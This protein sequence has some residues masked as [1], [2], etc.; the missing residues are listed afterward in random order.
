MT[1]T[2]SL[3]S[4]DE[5]LSGSFTFDYFVQ[6]LRKLIKKLVYSNKI[7]QK[8]SM[9]LDIEL[10]EK[11]ILIYLNGH[12]S[13]TTYR[14]KY[15]SQL[16]AN[17]ADKANQYSNKELAHSGYYKYL[18]RRYEDDSYL[19][20][21]IGRRNCL[22]KVRRTLDLQQYYKENNSFIGF[23]SKRGL[24]DILDYPICYTLRDFTDDFV[25]LDG[26]HRRSVA[27]FNGAREIDSLVIDLSEIEDW[28]NENLSE[29]D[30][31]RRHW[32][33]YKRIIKQLKDHDKKNNI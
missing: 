15:I 21:L 18:F 26:S 28:I 3:I 24:A 27:Y 13:R 30:Y 10:V 2:T 32:S 16:L 9:Q 23:S 31:F 1:N 4:K 33:V 11:P 6:A 14:Y 19:N 12:S 7:G 20:R 29:D 8:R 25:E 17:F 22:I 5:R